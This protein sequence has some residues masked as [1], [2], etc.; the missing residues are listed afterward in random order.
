M[1][2][3]MICH[4]HYRQHEQQHQKRHRCHDLQV[5]TLTLLYQHHQHASNKLGCSLPKL[6]RQRF[7]ESNIYT[8]IFTCRT[9]SVFFRCILFSTKRKRLKI[10]LMLNNNRQGG[11]YRSLHAFKECVGVCHCTIIY[12]SVQVYVR[13]YKCASVS[14]SKE[15]HK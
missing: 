2:H 3:T 10:W 8:V 1:P 14:T 4:H 11:W 7:N 6:W 13:V 12:G 5:V 9:L 15:V